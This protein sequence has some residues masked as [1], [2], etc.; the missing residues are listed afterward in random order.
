MDKSPISVISDRRLELV[1]LYEQA[2]KKRIS[3]EAQLN[4]AKKAELA[5]EAQCIQYVQAEE[6]LTK[7][8]AAGGKS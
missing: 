3:L 5:L 2:K 7:A 6:K 1:K 4:E 8:D